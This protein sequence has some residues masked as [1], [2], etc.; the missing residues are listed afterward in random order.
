MKYIKD[1][2]ENKRIFEDALKRIIE[3]VKKANTEAELENINNYLDT[4]IKENCVRM[5]ECG[6]NKNECTEMKDELTKCLQ[7]RCQIQSATIKQNMR[8]AFEFAF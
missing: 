1:Y 6:F 3:E 5:A 2:R 7:T 8:N 4:R